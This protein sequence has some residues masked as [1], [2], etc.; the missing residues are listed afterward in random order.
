MAERIFMKTR[1]VLKTAAMALVLFCGHP[2]GWSQGYPSKPVR[3]VEN[4][5]SWV[6]KKFRD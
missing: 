5:Y 2:L 6:A 3:M 4:S 1:S